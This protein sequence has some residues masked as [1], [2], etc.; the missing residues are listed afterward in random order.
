MVG[1]RRSEHNV[2]TRRA[3]I[4]SKRDISADEI[5]RWW[6]VFAA[7]FNEGYRD[8]DRDRVVWYNTNACCMLL[9]ASL[10]KKKRWSNIHVTHVMSHVSS[11]YASHGPCRCTVSCNGTIQAKRDHT[12]VICSRSHCYRNLSWAKT[13]T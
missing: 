2:N 7:C 11:L 12:H 8:C 5:S 6:L 10:G 3:Q 9:F 4:S 13:T 1:C